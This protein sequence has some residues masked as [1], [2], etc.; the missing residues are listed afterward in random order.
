MHSCLCLPG[1][2]DSPSNVACTLPRPIGW[3]CSLRSLF[4][5]FK[6][7]NVL[8][9]FS[10]NRVLII[11]DVRCSRDL[12]RAK[13]WHLILHLPHPRAW[14]TPRGLI[15]ALKTAASCIRRQADTKMG[16][17]ES[18]LPSPSTCA[19]VRRRCV[20]RGCFASLLNPVAVQVGAAT[21]PGTELN[22]NVKVSITES[23][24]LALK[25]LTSIRIYNI[26]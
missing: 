11:P 9:V 18:G 14:C 26:I 5:A 20:C 23:M 19:M 6:L 16:E 7:V 22:C 10:T 24:T 2:G 13:T 12:L 3:P 1:Y 15:V 17:L 4:F 8:E 21:G 25:N